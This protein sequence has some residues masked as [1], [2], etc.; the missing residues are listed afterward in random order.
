MDITAR[1]LAKGI[2]LK[3]G[4]YRRALRRDNFGAIA[5]LCYHG[6]RPDGAVDDAMSFCGV[7][8]A[9]REFES[10]CRFLREVCH[11][12]GLDQWKASLHG[13]APLPPRPVLLTFDD[14][15]SSVFSLARPILQKYRIPAMVFVCSDP[16]KNQELF[17]YDAAARRL[18]EAGVEA[19]RELTYAAWREACAKLNKELKGDD[20]NAPLSLQELRIL[21]ETPGIEIGGHTA[22]HAIL[23]RAG[24]EEQAVEI[25]RNKQ[26]LEE[27]TGREVRA[28]A[29]P[30][31]VPETDY[32]RE[33][34]RVV[35]E[36]GYEFAFTTVPA[37]ARPDK[38]CLEIPRF[39]VLA[40]VSEAELGHRL[41]YSWSRANAPAAMHADRQRARL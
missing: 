30:N 3:S 39:L 37:F 18:G 7:H 27:W 6:L 15:Y 24:R 29:Y 33:S 40:G 14:G 9:V 10:H 2:L 17:W 5:V 26:C 13:G 36:A 8:V 41:A 4:H 20:P 1:S 19:M 22:A 28:F 12:I 21:A 11:P 25:A 38:P 16:V 32:N 23:A 35:E 34:V 31:G